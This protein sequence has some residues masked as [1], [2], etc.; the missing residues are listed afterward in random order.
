MALNFGKSFFDH[1]VPS[2][3]IRSLFLKYDTVGRGSLKHEELAYLF[4]ENFGMTQTEAETYSIL[5]DKSGDGNISF[6]DFSVWLRSEERFK[7]LHDQKRYYRIR[8]A[9]ECFKQCDRDNDG[10]ID[11]NELVELLECVGCDRHDVDNVYNWLE[12]NKDGK[13][14]FPSFLTWLNWVP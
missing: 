1:T 10:V 11:K 4:T 3:V 5:L 13:I 7:N 8:K 14:S 12:K 6:E 2:I 9:L